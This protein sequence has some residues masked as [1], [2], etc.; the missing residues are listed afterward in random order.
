MANA[1]SQTKAKIQYLPLAASATRFKYVATPFD[2]LKNEPYL[3]E[4]VVVPDVRKSWL[5]ELLEE[6]SKYMDRIQSA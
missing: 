5:T 4:T 6:K 3:L 2:K 1:Y